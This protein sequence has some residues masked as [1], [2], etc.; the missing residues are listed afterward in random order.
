MHGP[1]VFRAP[2]LYLRRGSIG[3][4]L[5]EGV[6]LFWRR[7]QRRAELGCTG[8]REL[9]RLVGARHAMGGLVIDR[10]EQRL[11]I[12][13]KN[14]H[15]VLKIALSNTKP[16]FARFDTDRL[17]LAMARGL[18]GLG[19]DVTWRLGSQSLKTDQE[20]DHDETAMV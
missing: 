18:S 5:L 17:N 10:A 11:V 7:L 19:L 8:H 14:V 9:R 6:D 16:A 12:E 2:L 20:S 13:G 3:H 1:I 15:V 4:Q